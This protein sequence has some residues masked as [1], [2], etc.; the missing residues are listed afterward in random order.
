MLPGLGVLTLYRRAGRPQFTQ[1]DVSVVEELARRL[2]VGLAN[3]DTF[4]REHDIA[5]TLQRSLLP[6]ALPEMPGLDL[7]VRYLPATE[8]A[9]V[10]GDWYDAF[11]IVG[12]RVGLVIGDVAGHNIASASTMGQ[13]SGL[14]R[15]YAIDDTDPGYALQR[16]NTA[17]AKLLPDALASVVYAVLDPAAGTLAYANAGHP[18]PVVTTADGPPEYLDDTVGTML[19]ASTSTVFT[20]GRRRLPPGGRLVCYTDGLIEDRRHDISD[21]FEALAEALRQFGP[22]S[23]DQTC[24]AVLAALASTARQ[25]DICL[26]TARLTGE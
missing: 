25:D 22:G 11:P 21:G 18:P 12:S 5:E 7:A 23:A 8:G 13:V 6:D 20:T 4:A 15:A 10:G 16:T 14:L 26:L 3:T 1:T 2:A 9:A 19:G 24:A 17:V